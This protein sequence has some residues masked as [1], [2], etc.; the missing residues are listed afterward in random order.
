MCPATLAALI[1]LAASG[2]V[3]DAS[4]LLAPADP[5]IATR[6]MPP[7]SP[8]AGLKRFTPADPKDW[9]DLNR[10]ANP[11]SGMDGM[12]GTMGGGR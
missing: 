12:S 8:V 10:D 2:C 5:H 9:R 1:G 11:Q 4:M 7:P 3:S 6:W